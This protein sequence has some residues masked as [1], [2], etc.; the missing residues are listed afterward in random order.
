M[1]PNHICKYSMCTFGS[2]GGRKK[3]YACGYCDATENW[4]SMACCKE[5]Y[6]LY[7]QEVLTARE[8]N[9][10]IDTLPDRIDLTK[11]DIKKLK[12][13]NLKQVKK[14]TED[15]LREYADENGEVNITEAVEKIN[16]EIDKKEN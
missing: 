3:Y 11:D 9:E 6:N 8:K 7:M 16:A 10:I 2:D 12:K 1:R 14:E 13:K 15:E 4:K 5:H